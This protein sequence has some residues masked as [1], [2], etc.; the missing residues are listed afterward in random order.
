MLI[1]ETRGDQRYA[2][3]GEGSNGG[4]VVAEDVVVN[5][6]VDGNTD[7]QSVLTDLLQRIEVL[8][9]ALLSGSPLAE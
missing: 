2:L 8:E 1:N 5:P 3:K 6:A 9:A 7:V 4:P